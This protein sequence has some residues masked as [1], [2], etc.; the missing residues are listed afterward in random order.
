VEL[1]FGKTKLTLTRTFRRG[2]KIAAQT[3]IYSENNADSA[4]P[5]KH[6]GKHTYKLFDSAK[7]IRLITAAKNQS[8]YAKK[9][10]MSIMSPTGQC[11]L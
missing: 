2:D 6:P 8:E 10:S 5:A 1:S 4:A 7:F 9:P 3:L 11:I